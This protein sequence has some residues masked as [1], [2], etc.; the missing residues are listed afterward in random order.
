M[1]LELD[2]L[3]PVGYVFVVDAFDIDR[4]FMRVVLVGA[5]FAVC[6]VDGF[7]DGAVGCGKRCGLEK[8]SM[9]QNRD[10]KLNGRY[11]WTPLTRL[12]IFFFRPG[13]LDVVV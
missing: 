8:V 2:F 12:V 6:R 1:Q 9:D 5:V 3:E 10:H 4:P 11:T 13:I 7:G